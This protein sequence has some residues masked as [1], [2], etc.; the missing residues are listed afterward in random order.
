MSGWRSTGCA[1]PAISAPSSAPSTR[2]APRASSWSARRPIRF[3]WRRC[4]RRWARSSPCRSRKASQEAFLAWRKGFSGLVAGTHLKGAVDYRSVD[5]S[6]RPVLLLMGN[7]QQGL[8]DELAQSLRPAAPDSAGRP[9][10]FAQSRGR[11]RRHAVRDQ[12]RGADARRGGRQA[13]KPLLALC[14]SR[15]GRRSRSTS[16]S[17]SWSKPGSRC[18]RRSI[19]CLS[20]RSTAP[21]TPASPS[22]CSP[23]SAT[24]A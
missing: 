20:W 5:F 4:G 19:S 13:L 21:T 3:R 8:P 1:I 12:A 2:S 18:R 22:R 15:R 7:E 9:R 6:G 24:P 23:R 10:R 17:S 16:G 14:R 11:H